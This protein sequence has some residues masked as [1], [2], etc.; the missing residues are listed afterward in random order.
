MSRLCL[1]YVTAASK[2]EAEKISETLIKERLAACC[3]I[4]DG[5]RSIYRWEGSLEKTEET[6]LII[7]TK[8]VL[9]TEI[10]RR[11]KELHSYS[12]PCIEVLAI[13]DSSDEYSEWVQKETK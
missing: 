1:V 10:K 2:E 7:K 13:E 12:C 6:V 3:N 9:S 8:Y 4:F 11:V 5:V